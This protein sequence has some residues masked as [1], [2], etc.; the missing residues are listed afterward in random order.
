MRT[1][2]LV[3][4]LALL[5]CATLSAEGTD[6]A[7]A[8]P[9][10]EPKE[11]ALPIALN[12]LP[13]LGVGSFMQRDPLGGFICLGGDL[14]GGGIAIYG[15][16]QAMAY[17]LFGGFDL[18]LVLF[19]APYSRSPADTSFLDAAETEIEE[20]MIY[21]CVGAGIWTASKIFGVVR[22][23][24]FANRYNK[25]QGSSKLSLVPTLSPS[26]DSGTVAYDPGIAIKL[27]Y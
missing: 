16:A 23:I 4:A 17:S 15:G 24:D 19:T 14:V 21:F 8:V 26:F 10:P 1:L 11:I 22:P 7:K 3:A 6:R 5:T 12:L 18:F 13:G 20:G 9:Q 25:E 2:F 27:S